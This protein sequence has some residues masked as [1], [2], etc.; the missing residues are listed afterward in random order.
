MKKR[1]ECNCRCHTNP[2]YRHIVACCHVYDSDQK[3][4]LIDQYINFLVA[5]YIPGETAQQHKDR[6]KGR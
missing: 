4:D 2:D 6:L 3:K 1:S 5:N